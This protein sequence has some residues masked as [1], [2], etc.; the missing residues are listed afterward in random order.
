[1]LSPE[2]NRRGGIVP[3]ARLFHWDSA[4]GIPAHVQLR[5]Q[6][7]V[8]LALGKLGP[9]DLL[10][11]IR[12]VEQELGVGRMLVRKAYQQL[13]QAG[14]IRLVHGK[15][16]VVT[17][18]GL[19]D[20]GATRRADALV[21][22]FVAAIRREALEPVT[23]ARLFLQ[24][25]LA[26]DHGEP[27]LVYVDSSDTIA[28]EMGG[29]IQQVLGLRVRSMSV[30]ELK[31]TGRKALPAGAYVLVNY[32][33]LEEVRKLLRGRGQ[34]VLP[35]AWQFAVSFIERLRAL[36]E[37]SR[38]LLL[39]YQASLEQEGT[40]LAIQELISRARDRRF[41][42]TVR[43]VERVKLDALA[44]SRYRAILVSNQVWDRYHAQLARHPRR[45]WRLA[46]SLDDRSLQLLTRKLGL[47]L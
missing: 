17:G 26:A 3:A 43:P 14:L 27:S 21:R 34:Q 32:Y 6:V 39:F 36:P 22:R 44:R 47:V 29:Q 25:V 46:V 4:S 7:K 35:V 40:R 8:A 16:A 20:G 9:G 38:I 19:P 1:M 41:V 42:F 12:Q 2:R 30:A 11:S 23:F 15:G 10:P 45:F 18:N 28:R 33:Y 37:G 13:Q 5:E 24:R 31:A